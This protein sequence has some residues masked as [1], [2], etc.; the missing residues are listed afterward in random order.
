MLAD[1]I[2]QARDTAVHYEFD[3]HAQRKKRDKS[4]IGIHSVR[5]GT[6]VGEHEI[7]FA[8]HDE[9]IRLSHSAASKEV[10]A[11]GAIRAAGFLKDQPAGL[12]DMDDLLKTM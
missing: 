5:G 10:F 12:Y 6:I 8:G 1:A 3:R 11:Q 2:S 7:I 9:V 4:E